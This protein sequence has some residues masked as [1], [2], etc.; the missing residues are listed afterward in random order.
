MGLFINTNAGFRGIAKSFHEFQNY[1]EIKNVSFCCIRQWVLRLGYGILMQE[2]E[3]RNDWIY[4]IDF[5]IQLGKERCLLI[6]GVTRQSLIENGYELKHHQVK[7]LDIYVREHFEGD[8]VHQR[9]TAVQRKTGTPCQ[10]ISDDGAD[11]KKGISL[12]VNENENVISTYDI[13]HMIGVCIKHSLQKDTSW[14]N[15]QEDLY[16]LTNQIKQSDVSFLRPIAL[17]KKA[18]WLNIKLMIEWLEN[19]YKYEERGDFS[20]ICK[21][22][23]IV[24]NEEIFNKNKKKC[25]NKYEEKR[26]AKELKDTVFE[27]KDDIKLLL[28][29]YG[30]SEKQDIET[31]DAGKARFDEKFSVLKKHKQFY[32]ELKQ[33]NQMAENIKGLMRNKGLSL[34]TLEAIESEYNGLGCG[35]VKQVFNDINSRLRVEH[36]KCDINQEPLLCCSEIIE[37][38]FGKYKMK[39]K[40]PVGGIYET[41]LSIALFCSDITETTIKNILTTVRMSDVDNWFREMAGVSN[42]AKRRIAFA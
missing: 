3:K 4:I 27:K 11:V 35:W 16:N 37:S 31:I 12:F 25:K 39:A 10:I 2:V 17:S 23:K 32:I 1:F 26:F 40:Q 22:Y 24:N 30:V 21:G 42:L 15:L 9:I 6:L 33:L 14:L 36:G 8:A 5:S 38:I 34:E 19:I 20:L 28:K 13:T 18:R 7:V 41:V 29:K